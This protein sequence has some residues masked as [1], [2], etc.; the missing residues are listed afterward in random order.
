MSTLASGRNLVA[1]QAV[2]VAQAALDASVKYAKE[3][4]QFGKPIAHYQGI[5][6][7]LADMATEI[8]AARLLIYQAAWLEEKGL[9]YEIA[10]AMSSLFAIV[11]AVY[12]TLDDV[13]YF[14]GYGYSTVY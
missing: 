7:K 5:S 4:E 12:V 8:E 13:Q 6:F 14:C 9:S 1:A 2:G 10:S 11:M 3:R